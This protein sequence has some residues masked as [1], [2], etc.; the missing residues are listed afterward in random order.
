MATHGGRD[1]LR[2]YS[3]AIFW[4]FEFGFYGVIACFNLEFFTVGNL[5]IVV[6][7]WAFHRKLL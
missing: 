1:I 3:N 5:I 4:K 2:V 6:G 7:Y